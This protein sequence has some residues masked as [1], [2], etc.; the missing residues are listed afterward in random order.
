MTSKVKKGKN[1]P[2]V[3]TKLT[4]CYHNPK[5]YTKGYKNAAM[6]HDTI[7]LK[8]TLNDTKCLYH[9][10]TLKVTINGKIVPEG[11]KKVIEM[12]LK[13]T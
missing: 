5:C 8:V 6:A 7:T 2:K 9:T 12:T 3:T 4:K 11:S 10:M 1:D 13:V